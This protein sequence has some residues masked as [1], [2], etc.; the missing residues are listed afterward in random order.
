MFS[1]KNRDR[2]RRILAFALAVV[3]LLSVCGTLFYYLVTP[4]YAFPN[5]FDQTSS[6]ESFEDIFDNLSHSSS[7][8]IFPLP[9]ITGDDKL[10]TVGLM[11]ANKVTVGFET[12]AD[13]GFSVSKVN[14]SDDMNWEEIWSLKETKVSC[15]VDGNL[16]KSAMTY[17]RSSS[18]DNAVIGGWH[19]QISGE[20][21][22]SDLSILTEM[23]NEILALSGYY[24]IPSYINGSYRIRIGHFTSEIGAANALATLSPLLSDFTFTVVSPSETAV[25]VVNPDNDRILFE[26]DGGDVTSLGLE[27][28][29]SPLGEE[30]YLVTP[31]KNK[32]DGIF[33]FRRYGNGVSLTNVL[34]LGDYVKG[35]LPYE[36]GNY[37]PI[38]SQKAL[39][40]CIRSHLLY[41]YKHKTFMACNDP[42]C[43]QQYKGVNNVNDTVIEAVDSTAG[44]VIAYDG[45][46]VCAYFSAVTGGCTVGNYEGF[47]GGQKPYLKAVDTPWENYASHSYGVWTKEVSP[48]SLCEYLRT[49]DGFTHLRGEIV[50]IT[51]KTAV[52]STYI[53]E[54]TFTDSHGNTATK[55][56]NIYAFLNGGTGIRSANFVVGKGSVETKQTTFG[57]A[58][59][60][61][62]TVISATGVSEI[63]EPK[64]ALVL[65]SSGLS[66]SDVSNAYTVTAK[67]QAQIGGIQSTTETVTVYATN[68]NNF[69]FY[70]KGWGHGVGASQ[71]GMRDLAK[72]GYGYDEILHKYFTDIDIIDWRDS[73]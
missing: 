63:K 7:G 48:T 51:T 2:F 21:S 38:E 55:K 23:F 56:N 32:Y 17:S 53:A 25:S 18:P 59:T 14:S 5:P 47:G 30:A 33:M 54:M 42:G 66:L 43:C 64:T 8:E 26:Y 40:V 20:Y 57:E 60:A 61:I 71:I 15:T 24:P 36:I 73:K 6:D 28:L 39:A 13:N 1:N 72:L 69:V 11:Y 37:W 29:D 58:S 68:P 22:R 4:L 44:L 52:N 3:L 12:K 65:S 70:G 16:T 50:S 34:T 62:P 9:A 49:K 41:T 27:P 45:E 19:I 35:V 10:V 46:G 31:A 67:G